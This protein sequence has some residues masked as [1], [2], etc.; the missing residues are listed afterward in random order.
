M[1]QAASFPDNAHAAQAILSSVRY[2]IELR[3]ESEAAELTFNSTS[4]VV[5]RVL[6]HMSLCCSEAAR[7]LLQIQRSAAPLSVC[8]SCPLALLALL[9]CFS[10]RQH[11]SVCVSI[12]QHVA[13]VLMHI[14]HYLCFSSAGSRV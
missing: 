8:C 4:L 9:L 14:S 1:L 7:A 3:Y 6:I 2:N 12:R 11:T 13:R 5:A 10:I